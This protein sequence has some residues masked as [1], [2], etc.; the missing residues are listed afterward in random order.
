MN[1]KEYEFISQAKKQPIRGDLIIKKR[2]KFG[3]W[4]K[5]GGGVKKQTK[6][7]KIQIRTFKIPFK[8]FFKN[9]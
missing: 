5:K 2:E 3:N 6:N 1:A 9:V 7:S 4:P 8:T